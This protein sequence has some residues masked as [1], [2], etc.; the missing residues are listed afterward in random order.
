MSIFLYHC[1]G[2]YQSPY[3][4]LYRWHTKCSLPTISKPWGCIINISCCRSLHK[5]IILTSIWYSSK[6]LYAIRAS[7]SQII[8]YLIIGTKISS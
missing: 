2:A 4:V 6:V 1:F 5:N 8:F 7:S 3:N